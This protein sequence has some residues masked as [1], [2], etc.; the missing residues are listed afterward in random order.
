MRLLV[1]LTILL[2]LS[3][4]YAQ[5]THSALASA[6]QANEP[7]RVIR[8]ARDLLRQQRQQEREAASVLVPVEVEQGLCVECKNMLGLTDQVSEILTKLGEAP[9]EV[10]Q[11]AVVSSYVRKVD[12]D[13]NEECDQL[14]D[15]QWTQEFRQPDLDSAVIIYSG[16]LNLDRLEYWKISRGRLSNH[17]TIGDT[18]FLRGRGDDKDL[19]IRLD[20]N[21]ENPDQPPRVTIFRLV[22][23]PSEELYE[24][25]K[26]EHEAR[27]PL[28]DI[29]TSSSSWRPWWQK[30]GEYD[31]SFDLSLDEDTRLRL[32]P[33][34]EMK[35]YL[36]KNITFLDFRSKHNLSE[37]YDLNVEG[38]VS[39]DRQEARFTLAGRHGEGERVWIKV[40][41]GGDYDVG[42][43]YNFSFSDA[44]IRG[45]LIANEDG[46][47]ASVVVRESDSGN[48]QARYFNQRG[49]SNFEVDH[50]R[51]LSQNTF[52][53]FRL[54]KES[55]EEKVWLM[56]RYALD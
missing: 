53:T 42:V 40:R 46:A 28:P 36:P 43:P 35:D 49:V 1:I 26:E 47:G 48:T 25:K 30:R 2:S 52:M 27:N 6:I 22:N 23:V 5:E 50:N 14:V 3:S 51:K 7:D 18:F 11:L 9:R 54:S 20:K 24:T 17:L 8:I 13:G 44:T 12:Q 56:F 33:R 34:V 37:N 55:G 15:E 38:E 10:E 31:G 19:F 39:T 4:S 29:D 45:S 41:P 32:G 21:K 16:D